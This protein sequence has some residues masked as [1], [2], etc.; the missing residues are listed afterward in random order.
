MKWTRM[1]ESSAWLLM[2]PAAVQAV[3][4][5]AVG[6]LALGAAGP[7]AIQTLTGLLGVATVLA[8]ATAASSRTSR[9]VALTVVL[10]PSV[11]GPTLSVSAMSW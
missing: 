11:R 8:T 3:S 9:M 2:V 7:P 1:L 10:C 4:H 6:E 5:S